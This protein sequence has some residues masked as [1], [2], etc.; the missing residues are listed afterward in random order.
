MATELARMYA[1]IHR[2][3][4]P[5]R[6]T[7]DLADAAYMLGNQLACAR[8]F[9]AAVAVEDRAGALVTI[10]LF[11]DSASLEAGAGVADR[12]VAEHRNAIDSRGTEIAT[13]EVIAQ[14]GL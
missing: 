13:G 11:D 1:V 10:T 3:G 5:A 4:V 7:D 12:W 6:S 2:Y 8:G 14:K 9:V